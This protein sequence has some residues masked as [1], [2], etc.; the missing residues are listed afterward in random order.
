MDF[1]DSTSSDR[2]LFTS[3]DDASFT[4]ES[5]RDSFS[6]VD[7]A[8]TTN[9]DSISSIFSSF[10]GSEYPHNSTI[11]CKKFSPCKLQTRFFKETKGFVSD[12]SLSDGKLDGVHRRVSV[13]LTEPFTFFSK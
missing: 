1:S 12:S 10:Y 6:T 2:S 13:P 9:F 5:T 11:S 4:T 3:S 7:C 8:D